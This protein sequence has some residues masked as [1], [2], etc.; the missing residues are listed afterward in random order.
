LT[1]HVFDVRESFAGIRQPF[2]FLPQA[3][4]FP[5]ISK[6]RIKTGA[7]HVPDYGRKN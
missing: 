2:L 5:A 1:C 6:G 7:A 3:V 4:R